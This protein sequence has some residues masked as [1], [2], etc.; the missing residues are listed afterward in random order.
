MHFSRKF[1]SSTPRHKKQRLPPACVSGSLPPFESLLVIYTQPA[2]PVNSTKP[3]PKVIHT[4]SPSFQCLLPRASSPLL[5]SFHRRGHSLPS[6]S[7]RACAAN[8]LPLIRGMTVL[9]FP[10][11]RRSKLHL[12]TGCQPALRRKQRFVC[13]R[14]LRRGDTASKT[15]GACRIRGEAEHCFPCAAWG[16]GVQINPFITREARPSCA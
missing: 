4:P 5:V 9:L 12:R 14:D 11:F 1:P 2:A 3:G 8:L 7:L 13:P 6:R 10:S 15:P 16:P